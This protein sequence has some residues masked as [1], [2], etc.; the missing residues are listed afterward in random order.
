M[1][2]LVSVSGGMDSGVLLAQAVDRYGAKNVGAA[3]ATYPSKHDRYER[4]AAHAIASYYKVAL[5]HL[6]LGGVFESVKS[7]L[8]IS[9]GAIPEG[10]YE[11]ESMKRTVVP[12]RNLIFIAALAAVAESHGYSQIYIGAHAGDH[13]IPEGTPVVTKRGRVPIEELRVDEDEVMSFDKETN[14][15]CWK[16]VVQLTENGRPETVLR[17][18]TRSGA[19]LECT[20]DHKVYVVNQTG[21]TKNGYTKEVTMKKAGDL[22]PGDLLLTPS[23][24]LDA[25]RIVH[26][27]VDLTTQ[28]GFEGNYD[29]AGVWFKAGNRGARHVPLADYVALTAWYVTE[30]HPTGGGSKPNTAGVYISQSREAN[31]DKLEDIMTRARA[32]G[33]DPAVHGKGGNTAV[34]FSGPAGK[35]L[36]RCG[37]NSR[38]KRLPD[39][40][41]ELPNR[42]LRLLFDT[43]IAGDGH[44]RDAEKGYYSF[45]STSRH[46][47]GQMAY[48][49][50]RLGFKS[51]MVKMVSGDDVYM[52]EFSA[53]KL[54]PNLNRVGEAAHSP[55]VSIEKKRNL[56]PVYDIGVMGTHNFFAGHGVPVLVSNCIYPDCRPDFVHYAAMAVERS[57]EGRVTAV[58][59][60]VTHT[61]AGIVGLGMNLKFP[62]ELSRT[63]YKD[64]PEPCGKC[65]S[66]QERLEAFHMNNATDPVRYENAGGSE[67][68][69]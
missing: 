38:D 6:D 64:Q 21:W 2:T 61:K 7:D 59:P 27:K 16:P 48:I 43:M 50:S 25:D 36:R 4:P 31:P 15:L 20:P 29:E 18:T 58:A 69:A 49:A 19:V 1:K 8:L 55:I 14:K 13:C 39:W 35:V 44:V 17:F 41:L 37:V 33:L 66:C 40:F 23:G 28:D 51:S 24:E 11:A 63:C 68:P 12:G 53:G 10:H 47:L 26:N 45:V 52:L 30:G 62:F 32:W 46:L 57:T 22:E 5:H 34:Y 65:G 54:K 9:G 3:T 67:K 42:Y 60:F 56:V